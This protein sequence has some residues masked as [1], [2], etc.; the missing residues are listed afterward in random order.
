MKIIA[1]LLVPAQPQALASF[2]NCWF[3]CTFYL[4]LLRKISSL[5]LQELSCW[6]R[7][8]RSPVFCYDLISPPHPQ[9]PRP[10][11]IHNT[12]NRSEL[13]WLGSWACLPSAILED[14]QQK[15]FLGSQPISVHCAVCT[16]WWEQGGSL[17]A[18]YYYRYSLP[19]LHQVMPAFNINLTWL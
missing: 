12:R 14:K 6:L 19:Y 5:H 3:Y 17:A 16:G 8:T 10:S 7:Q 4:D 9:T 18:Y 13:W 11:R 2:I 15:C 1:L